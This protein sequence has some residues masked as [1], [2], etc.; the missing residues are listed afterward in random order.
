M[1]LGVVLRVL[2]IDSKEYIAKAVHTHVSFGS[3]AIHMFMSLY[4]LN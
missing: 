2:T 3:Y 4:V 1:L